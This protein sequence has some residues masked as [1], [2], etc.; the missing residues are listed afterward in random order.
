MS[1]ARFF[2]GSVFSLEISFFLVLFQKPISARV[3]PP[4]IRH[5]HRTVPV[6][7]RGWISLAQDLPFYRRTACQGPGA[8]F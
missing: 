3:G 1:L 4:D 2:T 5:H 8:E 7:A 6:V